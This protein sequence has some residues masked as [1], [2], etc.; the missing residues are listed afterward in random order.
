MAQQKN[1]FK[2]EEFKTWVNQQLKRTDDF[3]NDEYKAGLCAALEHVLQ[4][5]NRYQG[6]ND[7]YW[8]QKG[9]QEWRNAGEPDFPL[10]DQFIYGPTGQRFNRHYY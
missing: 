8:L 3:A 5:S 9:W 2:V 4:N 7:N 10:K 1:T 6:Y